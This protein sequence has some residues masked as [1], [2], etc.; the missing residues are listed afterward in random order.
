MKVSER[1]ATFVRDNFDILAWLLAGMVWLVTARC[2]FG[3]LCRRFP[4]MLICT[5]VGKS[6]GTGRVTAPTEI[7]TEHLPCPADFG[8]ASRSPEDLPL[9]P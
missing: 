5:F 4:T 6:L 2:G 1:K 8:Q 3:V 9:S 7:A